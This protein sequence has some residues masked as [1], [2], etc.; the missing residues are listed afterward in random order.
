M[1]KGQAPLSAVRAACRFCTLCSLI[2]VK[3][4]TVRKEQMIA[5]GGRG[6][7][8]R[9]VIAK[10]AM[11]QFLHAVVPDSS[12]D[13]KNKGGLGQAVESMVRSSP[14]FR[15]QDWAAPMDSSPDMGAVEIKSVTVVSSARSPLPF[16]LKNDLAISMLGEQALSSTFTASP[17]TKKMNVLLFVMGKV[18][19]GW[20]VLD[21]VRVNFAA[22]AVVKTDFFAMRREFTQHVEKLGAVGAI[23]RMGAGTGGYGK[24]LL[25]KTKGLG[26]QARGYRRRA[27]YVRR[28]FLAELLEHRMKN[29]SLG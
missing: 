11:R 4:F 22:L 21:V 16:R 26:G 13:P 17:L 27:L 9:D 5:L 1:R 3:D 7:M 25:S 8:V 14:W 24:T 23:D 15:S 28:S 20:R 19:L 2:S 6:C 29:W 10:K 12:F 18:Q